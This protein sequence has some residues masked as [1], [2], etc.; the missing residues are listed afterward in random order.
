MQ[1][2]AK[3]ARKAGWEKS[4]EG[5]S[6][7][8]G[9]MSDDYHKR[10]PEC[11]SV[12]KNCAARLAKSP[13]SQPILENVRRS[14][15]WKSRALVPTSANNKQFLSQKSLSLEATAQSMG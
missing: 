3:E 2:E 1:N 10:D 9:Q 7:G 11:A 8:A 5:K 6:F 13:P 14:I 12:S 4:F 15:M